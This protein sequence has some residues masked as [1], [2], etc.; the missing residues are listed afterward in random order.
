GKGKSTPAPESSLQESLQRELEQEANRIRMVLQ[1]NLT[2]KDLVDQISV[3]VTD[4]GIRLEFRDAPRFSFFDI[5]SAVVK[6]ELE[7]SLEILA[8]E[9]A[10]LGYPVV[11]EG[12][13]DSRPYG[14]TT[15]SNW[16]LS[17]DRASAVR[18]VLIAKG[19]EPTKVTEVRSY[20]DTR[21]L[22][23]EDPLAAENRRVSILLKRSLSAGKPLTGIQKEVIQPPIILKP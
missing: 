9:I 14:T 20:A 15:Y 10:R 13:T 7:R 12:H 8:P 1:N 23:P 11:I 4:E 19:L 21:L 2:L 5:G 22:K 3:E 18:R 6:P 17:A 16:E